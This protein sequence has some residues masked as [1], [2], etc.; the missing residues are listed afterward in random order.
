MTEVRL[1]KTQANPPEKFNVETMWEAGKLSIIHAISIL[2][3][4]FFPFSNLKIY[5]L[6]SQKIVGCPETEQDA[7]WGRGH[8]DSPWPQRGS[9]C[10]GP[11]SVAVGA[12]PA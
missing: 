1:S 7:L 10:S 11:D 9:H 4:I 5:A 12:D 8:W 2:F 3:G 6:W